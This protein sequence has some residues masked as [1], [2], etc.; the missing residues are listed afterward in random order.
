M[1]FE[2]IQSTAH[3]YSLKKNKKVIKIHILGN[4]YYHDK[5]HLKNKQIIIIFRCMYIENKEKNG[6]KKKSS[7]IIYDEK[8]K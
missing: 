5:F 8:I 2:Y 6:N 4:R 7:A 3:I 1:S